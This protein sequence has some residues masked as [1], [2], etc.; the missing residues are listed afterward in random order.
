LSERLLRH[1]QRARNSNADDWCKV[2]GLPE[3]TFFKRGLSARG[4]FLKRRL[5]RQLRRAPP[6]NRLEL[7]A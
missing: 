6:L 1:V 5:G 2:G 3:C 7:G 4:Q